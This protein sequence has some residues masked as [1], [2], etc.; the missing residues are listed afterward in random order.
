MTMEILKNYTKG[1][2]LFALCSATAMAGDFKVTLLG[3]GVPNPRPERFSQSTLIEAGSQKLIF[4][5]GRGTAVRVWQAKVPMGRIDAHFITHF[6]SDHTSGV[7]DL[8][9]T[10]WLRPQYGQRTQ[11]F[12][13]YGP[14]GIKKLMEGLQLAYEDDIKIRLEDEKNPPEGIAVEAHEFEAP[15]AG[16]T[17]VVYEKDG[18]KVSTFEVDHGDVIKPT[19]GYRIDY[20]GRS[21][22]LSSD[23]RFNEEVIRQAKG[24]DLLIHEV[25][26]I[27][28]E[29]LKQS[30][31]FQR[32]FAHHVSPE[33]AG[34]VFER[35][36]PK[37]AVY[38]HIARYDSKDI[39]APTDEDIINETRKTY[40]GPLVVGVDLMQFDIG[41]NGISISVVNP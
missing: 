33:Q 30:D 35:A 3:T 14:T 13:I 37:L 29:L 20:D 17:L 11:P 10:G 21:V 25:A 32:I 39:S 38:S 26:A 12:K 22:V 23:T 36:K 1:L 7:P 15:L 8:W 28:P 18:V 31:A 40:E 27:R 16:E 6:H 24:T 34:E 41:A 9:L 19:V 4:D 2:L 5:I